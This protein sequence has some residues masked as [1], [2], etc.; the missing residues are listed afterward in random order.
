MMTSH[1]KTAVGATSYNNLH[2]WK[3]LFITSDFWTEFKFSLIKDNGPVSSGCGNHWL[4]WTV[5]PVCCYLTSQG[6]FLDK[7]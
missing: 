3:Q 2:R 4:L 5:I 6:N 1:L 7:Q